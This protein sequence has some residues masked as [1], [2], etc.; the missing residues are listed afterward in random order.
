MCV[1]VERFKTR[2]TLRGTLRCSNTEWERT[3]VQSR[4]I[5][6]ENNL[7]NRQ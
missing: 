7:I 5:N 1:D 4:G 2:T 3:V 6:T